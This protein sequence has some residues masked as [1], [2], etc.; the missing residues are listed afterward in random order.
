M[1]EPLQRVM[2]V[3]VGSIFGSTKSTDR[4]VKTLRR[5]VSRYGRNLSDEQRSRIRAG[6]AEVRLVLDDIEQRLGPAE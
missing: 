3:G 1:N 6:V 5:Y 2:P 4:A